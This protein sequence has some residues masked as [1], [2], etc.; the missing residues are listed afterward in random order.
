MKVETERSKDRRQRDIRDLRRVMMR[1]IAAANIDNSLA[2]PQLNDGLGA[3]AGDMAP[4]RR[5]N[6]LP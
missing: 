2:L 5:S 4:A 3:T 1:A 6:L